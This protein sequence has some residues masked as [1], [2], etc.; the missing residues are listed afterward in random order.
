MDVCPGNSVQFPLE[1]SWMLLLRGWP[2]IYIYVDMN[3]SPYVRTKHVD[4]D[5]SYW[6]F[7]RLWGWN[8]QNFYVVSFLG[9]PSRWSNLK[10]HCARPQVSQN[11][12]HGFMLQKLFI[13]TCASGARANMSIFGFFGGWKPHVIGTLESYSCVKPLQELVDN[14]V[15]QACAACP[16]AISYKCRAKFC[17]PGLGE[18]AC[19]TAQYKTLLRQWQG[20]I[21]DPLSVAT[22][23]TASTPSIL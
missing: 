15:A 8:L 2:Q 10:I 3:M 5:P 18:S 21:V 14:F 4:M 11:L 17:G 6:R 9:D 19:L 23:A 22:C 7:L 1:F 16:A 20:K 12:V 13:A